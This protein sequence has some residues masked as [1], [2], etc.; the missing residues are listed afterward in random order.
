MFNVQVPEIPDEDNPPRF[1]WQGRTYDFYQNGQWYTTKTTLREFTPAS[2]TLVVSDTGG[3]PRFRFN[4]ITDNSPLSLLYAPAQPVWVSRT[5]SVRLTTTEGGDDLAAWVASP[6]L[7]AGESYQVEAALNN[8]GV[9]ELSTAGINYPTWVLDKYLQMPENFSPRVRELALQITDGAQNPYEQAT[10]IT[11]YLR[12]EIEYSDTVQKAPKNTDPL[13]WILFEYKKGYCVYY[14]TT[15]VLMLRS[16]EIPAR[17]AVGFAQGEF[18]TETNRYVVRNLDAHAWPEVY[19]PGIGWVEFEPTGNQPA[20]SRPVPE[21]ENNSIPP[22]FQNLTEL[23]NNQPLPQEPADGQNTIPETKT[24][25]PINPAFYLIPLLILFTTLTIYFSRRYAIPA[26][27]PIFLRTTIERNGSPAPD[28]VIH[29]EHWVSLSP[30]ERSFES[31]NFGLRFLKKPAPMHAT[32]IERARALSDLLPK[33]ENQ[34]K[35]L[36]DEHQTSLYTSRE[37]DATLARRAAFHIRI[38]I[39]IEKVRYLVEGT[40]TP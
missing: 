25:A 30:I 1:Y 2:D 10:L 21:D 9:N 22:P 19:F 32:P 14:A 33:I 23:E 17:M 39:L 28:W 36:L 40:R 24:D 26:R 7:E 13:E 18:S 29:W 34:V 4:F 37:A 3:Q 35:K 5:S 38:Q 11:Q 15:E 12:R 20:L 8:P 6:R 31:I 16:L 27:I